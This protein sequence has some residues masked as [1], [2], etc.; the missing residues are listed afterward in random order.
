MTNERKIF[1]LLADGVGLKNFAYS[2]FFEVGRKADFKS[3]FWNNTPFNLDLLSFDSIDILNSKSHP[4]SEIYKNAQKE[5]ELDLFIK[6]TTD[7]V[8]D[9]YRFPAQYKTLKS[10]TKNLFAKAITKF[11][12]SEEGLKSVVAKIEKLERSTDYYK[13]C[14]STLK[15]EHPALVFCTNQRSLSAIAA[16]LA[17]KDL[18]IPTACFIFS[19]DNLPKATL[20][21]QADYYFVWSDLMKSE[22]LF[23]YPDVSSDRIFVTGTPQFEN[24]FGQSKVAARDIFFAEHNLDIAKKYICYSGD[25]V[26]TSPDDPQYLADVAE[27]VEILNDQGMSLGVIFRRCPV[28]FSDRFDEVLTKYKNTIVAINPIWEKI[29]EG[30]NTILP[31]P[32]DMD[33]QLNT[34]AHTEMVINL[35]SSMVF[36]YAAHKKPCAYINYD[37]QNKV[38]NDWSVKKIYNYVHFRSMP[39]RDAVI[40]LDSKEEIADK[41]LLS[42]ESKDKNVAAAQKWFEIIAGATPDRS[43]SK[44]WE[45]IKKITG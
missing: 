29:G 25:D 6:K 16:I 39:T 33:L 4:L 18:N 13:K 10:S 12:S 24:H 22:L 37:V 9:S 14:I 32:Q 7:L 8:F 43:S 17:A 44:I 34:I 11:A 23:Y 36:D 2:N 38:L 28:D 31:K 26:T 35:G 40:W 27:A 1:V 42:M 15:K 5:I 45:A 41:I 21:V 3:I 30:W 19:W 20:V